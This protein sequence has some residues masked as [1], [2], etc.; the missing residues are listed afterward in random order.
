MSPPAQPSHG[1]GSGALDAP[2]DDERMRKVLA[3]KLLSQH[4]HVMKRPGMYIGSME[5][6][7]ALRWVWDEATARPVRKEVSFTP[8]MLKVF[9][10][11][12]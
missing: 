6:E 10:E 4:E 12:R 11:V 8:A 2:A 7:T 1:G 9:D 3:H 5:F